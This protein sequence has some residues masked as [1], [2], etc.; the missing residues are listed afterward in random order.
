MAYD[1]NIQALLSAAS[2]VRDETHEGGNTAARV[3]Q[4]LVDM[5]TS[6]DSAYKA[7]SD[8]IPE[9]VDLSIL[10]SY[11]SKEEAKTLF[12]TQSVFN[13]LFV[14]DT[15]NNA[16]KALKHLYSV[17]DITAFGYVESDFPSA[18]VV[19]KAEDIVDGVLIA[20]INGVPIYAPPGGGTTDLTGYATEN[21][22][23]TQGYVTVKWVKEQGYLQSVSWENI[24]NKPKNL[25]G[26]GVKTEIENL[27][28][29]YVT[30]E[31]LDTAVTNVNAY[32]DA[33]ISALNI[34]QYAT[35]QALTQAINGADTTAQDYATQA[36]N[37]AVDYADGK[38]V[39]KAVDWEVIDGIKM[40][41]GTY[42]F[43]KTLYIEPE[44]SYGA[45]IGWQNGPAAMNILTNGRIKFRQ[46]IQDN[47]ELYGGKDAQSNNILPFFGFH[48]NDTV[49]DF[50]SR[51]IESAQGVL[52]IQDSTKL[53]GTLKIGNAYLTYDSENNALFVKG[54]GGTSVNLVATGDVAA[55]SG[56]GS[57]FDTLT[58]L[59]LTNKLTVKDIQASNKITAKSI[60][61]Q[62][63]SVSNSMQQSIDMGGYDIDNC[64]NVT[65]QYMYTG[66]INLGSDQIT[67]LSA[68]GS[69]VYITINSARYKISATKL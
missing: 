37:N 22:V 1:D 7:L 66:E 49:T 63:L 9:G 21:W 69:Y 58:D 36:Y 30:N 23:T 34:D 64:Q 47:I 2:T 20:T 59:T 52:E 4:L 31:T 8:S 43:F 32:T 11:L 44:T 18:D 12:D 50:S 54:L 25:E 61:A 35:N 51:I 5:I 33:Q 3:G 57:G 56:L 48:F 62:Y 42:T 28:K 6:F 10:K 29:D 55:Y 45:Y 67:E 26:Y 14:E 19:I 39:T 17:S 53:S 68:S 16:I 65:C 41:N 60:D 40:L 13:R 46:G 38:F 15:T 24:Q 27:L